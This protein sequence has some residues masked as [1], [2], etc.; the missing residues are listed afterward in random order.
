MGEFIQKMLTAL[1]LDRVHAIGPDVG[2]SALLFAAYARSDLFESLVV[3]SGAS[4]AALTTGALKDLINCSVA[5]VL[6]SR[7]GAPRYTVMM[8]S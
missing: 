5:H 1:G 4:D 8:E 7:I 6:A 3:G 2:T